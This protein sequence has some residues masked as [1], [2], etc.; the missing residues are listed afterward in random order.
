MCLKSKKNNVAVWQ[1]MV[2][3]PKLSLNWPRLHGGLHQAHDSIHGLKSPITSRENR[4][5]TLGIG[6]LKNQPHIHLISRGCLLSIYVYIYIYVYI[7]YPLFKGSL[8]RLVSKNSWHLWYL[9]ILLLG[10]IL[11]VNILVKL[12]L[13]IVV[14]ASDAPLKIS[15]YLIFIVVPCPRRMLF[16]FSF[17]FLFSSSS[18][19]SSSSKQK[20]PPK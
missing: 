10:S 3:M 7:I 11:L 5:E 4:G 19:S 13:K 2:W 14:Q 8:P 20:V 18:S 9:K 15:F 1:C 6:F 17:F 12:H 16:F